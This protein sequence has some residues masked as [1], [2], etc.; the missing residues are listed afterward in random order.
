MF[1]IF[2][3]AGRVSTGNL[4]GGGG[5]NS[6]FFVA[7]MLTKKVSKLQNVD[8]SRIFKSERYI[9]EVNLNSPKVNLKFPKVNLKCFWK[10]FEDY[11]V[12]RIVFGG[13]MVFRAFKNIQ[14]DE[15]LATCSFCHLDWSKN[16]RVLDAKSRQK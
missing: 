4:G 9:P 10:V 11:L 16:A 15:C 7:E 12:S 5:L 8:N 6:F 3:G 2:F 14:C 13:L 1:Q